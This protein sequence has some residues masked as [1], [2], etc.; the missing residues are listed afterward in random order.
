MSMCLRQM[1]MEH[2]SPHAGRR[3]CRSASS[4]LFAIALLFFLLLLILLLLMSHGLHFV[5]HLSLLLI[6]GRVLLSHLPLHLCVLLCK[7]SLLRG[8]LLSHRCV[9]TLLRGVLVLECGGVLTQ[10]RAVVSDLTT[11]YV[12][13][14]SYLVD[15]G[16]RSA[17]DGSV[18]RLVLHLWTWTRLTGTNMGGR[19]GVNAFFGGAF[20]TILDHFEQKASWNGFN[21]CLVV[22]DMRKIMF[23]SD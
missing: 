10:L 9:L 2:V 22:R 4:D 16:G 19:W 23:I 8:V 11:L 17:M 20:A 15:L 1:L 21:G 13:L 18:L 12:L 5:A 6:H 3:T 7:L 14:V